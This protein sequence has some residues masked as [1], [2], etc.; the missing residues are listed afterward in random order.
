MVKIKG[1]TKRGIDT[2]YTALYR[3]CCNL[4]FISFIYVGWESSDHSGLERG[5]IILIP[6]VYKVSSI[7]KGRM[8][9]GRGK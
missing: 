2:E 8:T 7:S 6:S 4:Y 9:L 3:E 1:T 5:S